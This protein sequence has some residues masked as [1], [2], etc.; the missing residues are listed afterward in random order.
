MVGRCQTLLLRTEVSDGDAVITLWGRG[1]RARTAVRRVKDIAF[2]KRGFRRRCHNYFMGPGGGAHA[3]RCADYS[4]IIPTRC[5]C[6]KH[7]DVWQDQSSK[8]YLQLYNYNAIP[9]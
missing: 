3:P 4:N 5:S 7:K 2:T 9:Y 6:R 8:M 1:R